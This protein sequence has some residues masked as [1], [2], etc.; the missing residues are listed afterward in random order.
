MTSKYQ[1]LSEN[2]KKL[3]ITNIENGI[4]KL[5]PERELCK[6]FNVSRQTVR[7]ALTLLEE[8][9]MIKRIVGSGAYITGIIPGVLSNKIAIL[10]S[11]NSE[12]IYPSLISKLEQNFS[13]LGFETFFYITNNNSGTERKILTD[14]L[15]DPPRGIIVEPI[16]SSIPTP[17]S[18]LFYKIKEKKIPTLFIKGFYSNFSDCIYIKEDNIAGSQLLGNYLLSLAHKRIAGI[19][20]MDSLSG[21]EKYLGLS[22]AMNNAEL[23]FSDD[24]I[25]WFNSDLLDNLRQKNDTRFLVELISK[26]LMSYSS[27]VC[28]NDEIAYWLIKELNLSK[29]SVPSDISVVS[30]DNSYLST[31]SKQRITSLTIDGDSFDKVVTQKFISMLHNKAEHS[32]QLPWKMIVGESSIA[33][34]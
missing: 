1:I 2:L 14:L 28:Q 3:V 23:P 9:K 13:E 20:Q 21:H 6:L 19:F 18:D 22:L 33:I 30:F 32:E 8:E 27:I 4:D 25:F 24:D 10:I 12:Y 7:S 29:I 26:K 5:P 15:S 31:L 17:N 16:H 11:S 34:G